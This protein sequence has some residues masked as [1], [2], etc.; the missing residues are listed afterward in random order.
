MPHRVP[1]S[2]GKHTF[3][4]AERKNDMLGG[5]LSVAR[6]NDFLLHQTP[7]FISVLYAINHLANSKPNRLQQG[8]PPAAERALSGQATGVR[9]DRDHDGRDSQRQRAACSRSRA[10]ERY[11][12][13]DLARR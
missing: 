10:V 8:D 2:H 4:N 7:S 6:T 12:N 3:A 9:P 13:A 1:T 11:L 5:M